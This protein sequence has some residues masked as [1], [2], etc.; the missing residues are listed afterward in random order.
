MKKIAITQKVIENKDYL[1]LR[2]ALDIRWGELFK[3]L[4]FLPIVL[5]IN[6]DFKRYDF[7]GVILS[8]GNDVGEFDFRDKFELD[9]IKYCIENDI[10]VL[11]ICRGLQIIAKYF[12][13]SL[14]KV[15]G[16]V[17]IRHKLSVN[18][19]SKYDFILKEIK[20]VNSFHN[21]SIEKIGNELLIS[22]WNEDKSIIKA[23]EHKNKK[24][25]A[26]MWHPEREQ[27]FVKEELELVRIFFDR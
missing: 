27:P 6:Y 8:G 10:A 23:I 17:N 13:S 3:E 21:F 7:D 2:E 4:D 5:P 1:E 14:K 11:G 25:F 16:Q 15:K 18:K 19:N 9:L 12:G 22:A 20:K 24:I 26:T